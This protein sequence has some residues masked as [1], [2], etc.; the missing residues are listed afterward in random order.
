MLLADEA[1]QI[2][3]NNDIGLIVVDSLTAQFRSD[4]VEIRELA[5][6]EKGK[7][8]KDDVDEGLLAIHFTG[9]TDEEGNDYIIHSD[10]KLWTSE[11]KEKLKGEESP[12]YEVAGS[13]EEDFTDE[14]T[15]SFT[16]GVKQIEN[17]LED[18]EGQASGTEATRLRGLRKSIRSLRKSYNQEKPVDIP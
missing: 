1:Q 16:E 8:A 3:Q 2:C 5:D 15:Y 14:N 12:I 4:Y 13:E 10:P 17:Y 6:K 11:G 9:Y 18:I 7:T